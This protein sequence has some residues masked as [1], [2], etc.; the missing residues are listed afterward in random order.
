M[1]ARLVLSDEP[2]DPKVD[3]I[4]PP[5]WNNDYTIADECRAKEHSIGS[6]ISGRWKA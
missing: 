5:P 2:F 1:S 6:C 3:C 4:C